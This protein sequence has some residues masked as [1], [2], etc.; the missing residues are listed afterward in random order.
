VKNARKQTSTMEAL[1]TLVPIQMNALNTHLVSIINTLNGEWISKNS[2]YEKG[3]CLQLGFT[4]NTKRYW[5]CRFNDTY[6]EIKK[7]RS[8]WLDEVRYCEVLMS[9]T[10]DNDECKK[11]T[12]TIFIIPTKNK[13][14]IEK[15]YIIN[16]TKLIQFMKITPE[17]SKSLLLKHKETTRSLNCQQSMTIKDLRNIADYEVVNE[18]V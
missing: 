15:I 10:I 17:W 16:T 3:A 6:I 8:I 18:N 2:S 12:I 7:G 1:N 14:R 9:D 11:K 13:K 5:D 4:C